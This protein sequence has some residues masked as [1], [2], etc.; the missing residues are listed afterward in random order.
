MPKTILLIENDAPFA[1]EMS[2][3]LEAMGYQVRVTGDGKVGLELAREVAPD[4][5]VLCVELPKLSGYSI[6]NKLKKD[7]ALGAIPLV[8]TSS[9]A[10][11]EVF[12][13][14]RKLKVRAEEYLIKPFVSATLIEKL[15]RLIGLP[16]GGDAHTAPAAEGSLDG[17]AAGDEEVVSLED[18]L[19]VE[20]FTGE[21]GEDLPMLDLDSL[22]DEPVA[23]VT[24]GGDLEADLKLLDDAF[25]GLSAPAPAAAQPHTDA[26]AADA[27]TAEEAIEKAMGVDR[28]VTSE[29]L[30]AA[31]AS[32]PDGDEGGAGSG[33]GGLEDEA[34]LALGSL[35]DTP[36]AAGMV[37][38]LS[39]FDALD[40]LG[41]PDEPTPAGAGLPA[42]PGELLANGLGAAG[43][44]HLEA[45]HA[46]RQAALGAREAALRELR[47][48]VQEA[49][50]ALAEKDGEVA[51]LRARGDALAA[52]AKKAEGEALRGLEQARA[53]EARVERAEERA[54]SAEARLSA[55][56][57]RCRTAEQDAAAQR[58]AAEQSAATVAAKSAELVT[59]LAAVARLAAAEREVERL[60]VEV[61]AARGEM[62]GA[63]AEAEKRAIDLK[64][65]ISELEAANSKNE[66]RVVKAYLKIKG[67]EKVRDKARKALSI[68]LQ[69][70]EEGLPAEQAAEKRP[71]PVPE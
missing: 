13:D 64:R 6:C 11:Q 14:H 28:P 58:R 22:P 71:R 16:E 24:G 61:V 66:E 49:E 29:D 62:E 50:A 48:K 40:A 45:E 17:G 44:A 1:E 4:A 33:L 27:S 65:R 3:A 31:S 41:G 26:A 59:A 9:E 47:A 19:A 10:T 56:E 5:I 54:A 55:A 25:D 34:D 30:E 68:A 35:G 12:D 57:G 42:P 8:L 51:S 39:A 53:A 32:L 67:D 18:E 7:E 52:Q 36:D 15:A 37:T 60:G 43:L 23:P 70:L 63:R 2:G 69:L 20:P 46:E 38:P 21:P